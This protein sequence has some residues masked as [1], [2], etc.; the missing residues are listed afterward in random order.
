MSRGNIKCSYIIVEENPKKASA[1]KQLIK[2]Y[3]NNGNNNLWALLL[4]DKYLHYNLSNHILDSCIENYFPVIVLDRDP[5]SEDKGLKTLEY[6]AQS[7]LVSSK[8]LILYTGEDDLEEQ[9]EEIR[10]IMNENR[11]PDWRVVNYPGN[12]V[13]LDEIQEANES[14]FDGID[15]FPLN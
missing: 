11:I 2:N 12:L 6:I 13:E 9:G 5:T 4:T 1:I 3:Y 10:R 14:E 8:G 15:E 7:V